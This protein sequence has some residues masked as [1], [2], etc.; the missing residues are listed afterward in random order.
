LSCAASDLGPPTEPS[1]GGPPA[2]CL[3]PD[4][5][6]QGPQAPVGC[7]VPPAPDPVEA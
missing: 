4:L 2:V 1:V 3:V 5:P 7:V 6:P